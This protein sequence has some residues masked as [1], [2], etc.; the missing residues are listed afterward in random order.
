MT[1]QTV[2]IGP[3]PPGGLPVAPEP[4][5]PRG[6][7]YS[8][9]AAYFVSAMST[10]FVLGLLGYLFYSAYM[11][12]SQIF[13]L[14]GDGAAVL[15][16]GDA[17]HP[18]FMELEYQ[19]LKN[20]RIGHALLYRFS[21]SVAA[22]VVSLTTIVLGS[23]LIFDRV[24]SSDANKAGV[25]HKSGLSLSAE[26]SF[27]GM[28][29]IFLGTFSLLFSVYYAGPGA[30]SITTTDVPVFTR[31]LNIDRY[32]RNINSTISTN[33]VTEEARPTTLPAP[34]PQP[35]AITPTQD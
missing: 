12:S 32:K 7:S 14:N 33:V 1:D 3:I 29:M 19:K 5:I 2:T 8:R 11:Q 17:L 10:L 34:D 21:I 18:S 26:S 24:Y 16:S 31:D 13:S 23:V 27:P 25:N 4:F 28:I 30:P 20:A 9:Q 6:H 15:K 22:I 35:E